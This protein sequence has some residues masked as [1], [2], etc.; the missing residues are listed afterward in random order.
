MIL[1]AQYR[2]RLLSLLL[3]LCSHAVISQ[4]SLQNDGDLRSVIVVMRHGVRT[5][6]ECET[7]SSAYNA[8]PWP[9]WPTEPGVLTPHGVQALRLLAGF[10]RARY[11]SLLQNKSCDH[12]GIYV[13][14]NTSQ[15]TIAS[16]KA[17]LSGL[18]PQCS[19]QPHYF[20]GRP[21]LLF[22][23]ANSSAADRQLTADA[24]LGKMADRPKWFTSSFARP[25]EEM[26]HILIDCGEPDCDRFKPDFRTVR[27]RMGLPRLVI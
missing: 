8:Q 2:R 17:L 7:R 21:N 13:E 1:T 5:P 16:A 24:T 14:A 15:R 10:Y 19:L 27:C 20:T 23:P 6:I 25:L 18:S 9:A 12:A 26:H 22:T 11:L 4:S 3:I